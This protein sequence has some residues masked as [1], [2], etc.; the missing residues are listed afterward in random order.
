MRWIFGSLVES[1][2]KLTAELRRQSM[3]LRRPQRL[4][5]RLIRQENDMALVYAVSAAAPV[6]SDVVE[7][8]LTI[9]V[10]GVVEMRTLPPSATELGEIKVA[11]D[12]EVLLALVDA[13]GS[14]N[15]S[16]SATFEFV[17][18]DT[19]PPAKPGEF[20]VSLLRQED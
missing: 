20:G 18:V 15:V 17:A 7:R 10:D 4:R 8:R 6:D 3:W 13:D 14:G 12:A 9:E 16:E 2:N 1:I 11:R 19:I 5:V